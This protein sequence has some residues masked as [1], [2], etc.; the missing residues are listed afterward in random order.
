M[1]ENY[2]DY[3]RANMEDTKNKGFSWQVTDKETELIQ[4]ANEVMKQV[5]DY[6]REDKGKPQTRGG[7]KRLMRWAKRNPVTALTC[8]SAVLGAM[9]LGTLPMIYARI[10]VIFYYANKRAIVATKGGKKH[11]A[12]EK[13]KEK[14]K[15]GEEKPL[16]KGKK[17]K[18]K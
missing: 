13:E 15:H 11:K 8:S 10:V 17:E 1:L 7:V 5:L 14:G 2:T 3:V 18:T 16:K 4:A 9:A 6:R 12:G